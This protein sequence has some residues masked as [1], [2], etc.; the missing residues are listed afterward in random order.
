MK[1]APALFAPALLLPAAAAVALAR[2]LPAPVATAVDAAPL[3]VL[4]GGALVGLITRRARL[5]VAVMVLALA[6]SALLN[7]GGRTVFD[8]IALLLPLNIAVVV[9]LGDENP[10]AGRG[11]LLFAVTLLQAA[12][13]AV[14][15]N[16]GMASVTESLDVPLVSARLGMWTGL[17]Q[18]AVLC[19]LGALALV[20]ARFFLHGQALALGAAWALVASFLALDGVATG[21][22]VGVHFATAGALL[23]VGAARE[24][25]TVM[26]RDDVTRLPARIEFQRALRRLTRRYTLAYVEIDD[27]VHL[28][29]EHGIEG[30]HRILRG[31]AKRLRRLRE[32]QVYCVEGALFAV[33][34]PG[35]SAKRAIRVLDAV[36]MAIE[37]LTFEVAIT[38]P[39]VSS[40]AKPGRVVERTVSVTISA[41]VAEAAT[42]GADSRPVIEAAERAL[43]RA[44]E[45]GMNRV[46]R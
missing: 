39:A 5:M 9:W 20:V 13:I 23:L 15:L 17:S 6:D 33:L 25:R 26:A 18:L 28:R 24:P 11:A 27:Y 44:R 46:S 32:G 29:A 37:D 12:I 16:P 8:A 42:P 35:A 3:L 19:F 34:F 36:R 40:G 7:V 41:G 31:V 45:A 30:A 22:H 4:G 43:V 10:L 1:R 14:L 21:A 38:E 2:Q